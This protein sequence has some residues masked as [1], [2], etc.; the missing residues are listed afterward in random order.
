[1][2]KKAFAP[3]VSVTAS[4]WIGKL[5][6]F[7]ENALEK[8]H[9]K[10]MSLSKTKYWAVGKFPAFYGTVFTTA[11][12]PHPQPSAVSPHH[13]TVSLPICLCLGFLSSPFSSYSLTQLLYAFLIP[14]KH[15]LPC[16]PRLP[17]LSQPNN[18]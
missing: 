15:N 4:T 2:L 3:P 13:S 7:I 16:P 10:Q 11:A 9:R 6:M 12:Y 5:G 1:L 17:S 18:I 14:H 8:K